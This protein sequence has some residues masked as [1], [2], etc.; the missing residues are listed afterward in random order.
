MTKLVL[1]TV[2]FGLNYG[3]ANKIG[4]PRDDEVARILNYAWQEGIRDLDTAQA[5]GEAEQVLGH[6][7]KKS[8]THFTVHSKF[9]L[10]DGPLEIAL[11]KSLSTLGIDKLG[12]FFFHHFTD[13]L[14]FKKICSPPLLNSCLGLGVSTY[15]E[16]DLE[17]CLEDQNIKAIQLPLNLLDCSDKKL[18]LLEKANK[19]GKKIFI[20]SV[21]LQGLF[22]MPPQE[23]PS[24]L[25]S[26]ES[27][28]ISLQKLGSQ[29]KINMMS[30][31][32]GFVR[33]II[34][35]EGILIGVDTLEQ[36]KKN[37]EAWHTPF[38][39]EIN[40]EVRLIA[41]RVSD[42]QLLLPRNWK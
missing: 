11:S 38:D 15:Q 30:L 35:A 40:H 25:R 7:L 6:Y 23:L 21:F 17:I 32:L 29:H 5:Y 41:R 33:S 24:N 10:K 31:C 1:G 12:Y 20:R 22:L 4:K 14:E 9:S 37:L 28:I 27:S 36:L 26:L 19:L 39:P 3:I 18:I 16:E 2:Q 34:P 8:S 13:Y 42:P